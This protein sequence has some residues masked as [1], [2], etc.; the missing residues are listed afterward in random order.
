[1]RATF[2]ELPREY[3]FDRFDGALDF[4][5]SLRVLEKKDTQKGENKARFLCC[6]SP[7]P[8]TF[9]MAWQM[10]SPV[11]FT[12]RCWLHGLNS[13]TSLPPHSGSANSMPFATKWKDNNGL[14]MF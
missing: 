5:L 7:S 8:Q 13:A 1:M 3:R 4:Y 9:K 12:K 6:S 10:H 11:P 14:H 2:K